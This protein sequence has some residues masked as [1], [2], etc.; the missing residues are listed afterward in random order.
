MTNLELFIALGG[1]SAENLS[2]AE[3]LQNK[4]CVRKTRKMPIKRAVLIA[5]VIA[6]MLLLVGCAVIYVLSLQEIKIGEQQTSYDAFAYDPDTGLP[7][8]YLGKEAVTEQVLSFA[9]MKNTPAFQ[10]AQ[11]WFDFKQAYDPDGE[12]QGS[13]WGNEPEFPA[14]YSGYGLYTQEMKEKLDELLD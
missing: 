4:P 6:L 1:I 14:E 7:I 10:A 2:G 5:A 11:E 3:D 12:I 13:V 8:E 9:G